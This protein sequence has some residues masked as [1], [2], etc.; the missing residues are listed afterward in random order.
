MKLTRYDPSWPSKFEEEKS[1]LTAVLGSHACRIEHVGSTSVP[2]LQAKEV[3]DIQISVR[4]INLPLFQE[5]LR[6]VGYRHLPTESPPVEVYP[7]FHKPARWPTTHHVHLCEA[8]SEQEKAHIAFRNW[9]R[10]H[11]DDRKYYGT[12]KDDLAKD[13]D[14]SDVKTLFMYTEKKGAWVQEVTL[15]AVQAGMGD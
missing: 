12:L 6:L 7:F 9:L 14:E 2:E 11:P 5:K 4:T 13:V 10:T 1:R 8:G 15:K 3:I